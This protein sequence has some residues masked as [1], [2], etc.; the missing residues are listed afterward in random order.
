MNSIKTPTKRRLILE[1]QPDNEDSRLEVTISG[2]RLEL[3][4]GEDVETVFIITSDIVDAERYLDLVK[5]YESEGFRVRNIHVERLD[6]KAVPAINKIVGEISETFSRESCLILSYGRSLAPLL[7]TCYYIHEGESPAKAI[8][9]VKRIDAGFI[10]EE[11]EIAFVYKYKRFVNAVKGML[12]DDF[13]FMPLRIEPEDTG[14]GLF[15]P[16]I[17][18]LDEDEL[19][20]ELKD[21]PL[22]T[23]G[24][25]P[26]LRIVA[27]PV[28]AGPV[29]T[30]VSEPA[31]EIITVTLEDE[32]PFTEPSG[33]VM[34]LD[35]LVTDQPVVYESVRPARDYGRGFEK[36]KEAA[37][38][39]VEDFRKKKTMS[40]V[41]AGA[42]LRRE[43]A[44]TDGEA[45]RI[46]PQEISP[47]RPSLPVEPSA[48]VTTAIEPMKPSAKIEKMVSAARGEGVEEAGAKLGIY[49]IR[50]KLVSIISAI[51]VAALTG[52]IFLATYF[53]KHDN[54]LRAWENNQKISEVTGLKVKSDF[55]SIIERSRVLPSILPK[56]GPEE[57]AGLWDNDEDFLFVGIAAKAEGGGLR[58]IKS[59]YNETLLGKSGLSPVEIEAAHR[60]FGK[61]FARSFTGEVAVHNVS[62]AF[63]M[64]VTGFSL[65]LY[66]DIKGETDQILVS[67][68]RLD[69][70]LKAFKTTGL[71]RVFMVNDAGDIIAHPDG[72]MIISGGNYLKLPIVTLMMKSPLDNGQ[73]RYKNENGESY[74]GSFKKIGI[75]GCGVIAT[76]EESRAFEQVYRIQR[77]NFYLTV[78][79]LTIAI[80]IVFIFGKTITSPIQRLVSATA[81]IKEGNYHVEIKPSTKD[82]I[83]LLTG[84]FIE[85]GHGLEEREKMK[86]AFGKFVNKEIAD[87]VLRGEVRLGGERKDVAIF[88]SDIRNFTAMSEKLNPEEVVEFLNDYMTRM[89]KCVNDTRGVVDKYIGDAIMAIWGAPVTTGNDT[90]NAIESA[91]AMRR[92][93]HL[94]NEGRGSEKKPVIKIGCGIN[95]G[96]VL[97]GQIGSEERMEYTVIGD[98]VNLASRIETLNKPF[99]TDILISADSYGLVR[100]IY[101][102][103]PMQKIT[104]KGKSEPQQ[105]YAVLGRKDDPSAPKTID[106]LREILGTVEQPFRRRRDDE[107]E[108]EVKY[109][110]IEG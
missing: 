46:Q 50:F 98:A 16:M 92:E 9:R 26:E 7:V 69:R 90:E 35:D 79:I 86:E 106:E 51:M 36:Q 6:D 17:L 29:I 60:L 27:P 58:F 3:L 19:R 54:E 20:E 64:P 28:K 101:R 45:L 88:F 74:L 37:D 77:W 93:L 59:I 34:T 80:L 83:G 104:V 94:F 71:I 44:G 56:L 84:S 99:G 63:R 15:E 68:I 85:M 14:T 42:D 103:E 49:S 82:E 72:A 8:N 31:P 10:A 47:G 24:T 76:V 32:I 30:E 105:I 62:Q 2:E 87:R 25:K 95:T 39:V 67:Y 23:I 53:F 91:L 21:I 66:R 13:I 102:L 4:R 97:A 109:E 52:M 55:A 5:G 100:E 96:P 70:L 40:P 33:P 110:I 65:P 75:G 73:L 108:E 61:A 89:V 107:H 78:I 38:R 43:K 18:A 1:R 12:D 41:P 48:P 81:K 57:R 11:D 22:E